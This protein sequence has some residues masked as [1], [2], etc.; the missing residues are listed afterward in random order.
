VLGVRLENAA[1]GIAVMCFGYAV[2]LVAGGAAAHLSQ[3]HQL[4]VLLLLGVTG[5]VALSLINFAASSLGADLT[6]RELAAFPLLPRSRYWCRFRLFSLEVPWLVCGHGSGTPNLA[7]NR[8]RVRRPS[9]GSL[10][11]CRST[12]AL[13]DMRT[14]R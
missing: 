5:A 10:G 3:Q 14:R 6:F 13:C 12:R 1:H 9:F 7:V 11:T 2:P 8:T 4:A